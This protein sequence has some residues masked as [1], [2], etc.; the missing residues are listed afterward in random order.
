MSTSRDFLL[1]T[2]VRPV[3][4]EDRD[5]QKNETPAKTS[6]GENARALHGS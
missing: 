1:F 3:R 2:F 4:G 5:G 6:A